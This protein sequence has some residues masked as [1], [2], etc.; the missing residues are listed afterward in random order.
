MGMKDWL[1]R[2]FGFSRKETQG[3]TVL[4]ILGGML[5]IFP[6]LYSWLKKPE[7][8][9]VSVE[10]E[11]EIALFLAGIKTPNQD[12]RSA[13]V[14]SSSEDLNT[15]FRSTITYSKF[16]PNSL[17]LKQGLE[18]GLNERQVKMIHN[19]LSK[20]GRFYKKEDFAKI[21]AISEDD[22]IRLEPYITIPKVEKSTIKKEEQNSTNSFVENK[23]SEVKKK[24]YTSIEKYNIELNSTDSIELQ[25]L[26]GIGPVFASRIIKFRERLGGFH[27]PSQLLEVYGMDEERFIAISD[28]ISVNSQLIKKIE[29]NSIS[30]SQLRTQPLL[31]NK[32]ANAIVQYRTQH[33]KYKDI[34]D[35]SKVVIL[36]EDILLK[37]AP[38][39]IF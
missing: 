35:L 28:Q 36:N 23:R 2:Y 17:S 32:Q 34:Q 22:Y 5:F 19:Y 1:V 16:N 11:E 9:Q 39:L 21:Y 38:Y 14:A 13:A 18:L 25:L 29:I 7:I 33:G 31:T 6:H 20:G 10:N 15:A 27:S 8:E 26:H 12:Y 24:E 4:V 30:Y 37:I 3:L